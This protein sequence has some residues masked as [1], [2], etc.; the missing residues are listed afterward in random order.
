MAEER[1]G[2]S[3][4]EYE[5]WK[6]GEREMERERRDGEQSKKGEGEKEGGRKRPLW[7]YLKIYS[8][9]CIFL[10]P[11]KVKSSDHIGKET[12]VSFSTSLHREVFLP[13]HLG[14]TKL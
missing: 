2:G 8:S 7:I 5:E 4:A 10:V 6:E 13:E 11:S 14:C 12:Q 3:R 1:E 9:N